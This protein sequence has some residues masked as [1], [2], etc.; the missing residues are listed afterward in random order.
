MKK[1]KKINKSFTRIDAPNII[2]LTVMLLLLLLVASNIYK[3]NI[4]GNALDHPT[5][6][7]YITNNNQEIII[8]PPPAIPEEE[9]R[10]DSSFQPQE[11]DA[12]QTPETDS[13]SNNQLPETKTSQ[14]KIITNTTTNTQEKPKVQEQPL[15]TTTQK[16]SMLK[17][18]IITII[19]VLTGIGTTMIFLR[20]KKE[21][22]N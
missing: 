9:T 8:P 15:Q 5:Y 16:S 22:V 6:N 18:I 1:K 17:I 7:D 21:K 12:P 13:I 11:K 3:K 20:Q 10:Q 14:Q 4:Y 19:F 2:L